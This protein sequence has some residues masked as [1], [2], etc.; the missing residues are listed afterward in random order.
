[1]SVSTCK[2]CGSTIPAGQY[3]LVKAK[4]QADKLSRALRHLNGTEKRAIILDVLATAL[5]AGYAES[6][7]LQLPGGPYA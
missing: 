5:P 2:G 4:S 3:R 6:I 1:M 7:A